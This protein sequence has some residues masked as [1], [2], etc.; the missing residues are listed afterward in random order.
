MRRYPG[1]RLDNRR[2][3]F[4]NWGHS[5]DV[6]PLTRR[7]HPLRVNDMSVVRGTAL[8]NYPSLVAELGGDPAGLL[9]AA[10]IRGGDVGNYDAFIPLRAAIE[11]TESAARGTT[12]PA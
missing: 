11:A 7:G 1:V 6:R 3:P 12:P 4:G 10:G 8:S 9:R 5:W 2:Q